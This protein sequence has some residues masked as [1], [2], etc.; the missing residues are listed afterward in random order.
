MRTRRGV[1][2]GRTSPPSPPVI[3]TPPITTRSGL[4]TR[5]MPAKPTPPPP[6]PKTVTPTRTQ[7]ATR[8][9]PM[10][11][12]ST[13]ILKNIPMA[14]SAPPPAKKTVPAATP[15]PPVTRTRV[16]ARLRVWR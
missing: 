7:I 8:S 15:P 4:Q 14:K 9:T 2:G 13:S 5:S 1:V 6:A 11:T 12:K 3:N 16:S 10:T